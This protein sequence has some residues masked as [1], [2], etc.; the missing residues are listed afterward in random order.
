VQRFHKLAS[1]TVRCLLTVAV[2]F[3]NVVPAA[4]QM[5][6]VKKNFN[7]GSLPP[8]Q[9]ADTDRARKLAAAFP[10]VER[11]FN[12]WVKQRHMPGAVMWILIDGELPG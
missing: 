12:L 5:V 7:L 6:H 4:S 10:E 2:C 8:P 11:L 1:L 3:A 9:F